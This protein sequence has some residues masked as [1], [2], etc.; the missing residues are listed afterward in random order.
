MDELL[1][2]KEEAGVEMKFDCPEA[3]EGGDAPEEDVAKR[4]SD[5]GEGK[6]TTETL[7]PE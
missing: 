2:A 3:Q 5:D 4:Q 7:F 1:K 6:E